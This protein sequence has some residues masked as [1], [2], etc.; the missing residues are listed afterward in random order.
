MKKSIIEIDSLWPEPLSFEDKVSQLE[1]SSA[2]KHF[3]QEGLADLMDRK[4]RRPDKCPDGAKDY[5][6]RKAPDDSGRI[7]HRFTKRGQLGEA[8]ADVASV[9]QVPVSRAVRMIDPKSG[10]R[11]IKAFNL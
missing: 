7:R 11:A 9:A 1:A 8:I 3:G 6:R 4:S 5:G 2:L 10:N